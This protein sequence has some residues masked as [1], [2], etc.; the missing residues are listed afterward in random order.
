MKSNSPNPSTTPKKEGSITKR[1]DKLGEDELNKV[2][3]PSAELGEEDLSKVA[4]GVFPGG[5]NRVKN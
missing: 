2:T 5:W 1:K 3:G 4:G